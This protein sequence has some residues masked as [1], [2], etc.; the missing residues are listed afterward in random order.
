MKNKKRADFS[1]RIF[2]NKTY[3]ETSVPDLVLQKVNFHGWTIVAYTP[4]EDNHTKPAIYYDDEGGRHEDGADS[5]VSNFTVCDQNGNVVNDPYGL[6]PYEPYT[7]IWYMG[8]RSEDNIFDATC[9]A[10]TIDDTEYVVRGSLTDKDYA[11]YDLSE[12]PA[13]T[14]LVLK[15]SKGFGGGGLINI[16]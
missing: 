8:T 6:N 10:F 12:V 15:N 13:G 11:E 7:A 16:E 2:R 1:A 3:S 5:V 4:I 14:Y 9:R